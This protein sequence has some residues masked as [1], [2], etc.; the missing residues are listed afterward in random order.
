[1]TTRRMI[2]M[3]V[4]IL[5]V[6]GSAILAQQIKP[7]K[8]EQKIIL[9]SGNKD[10]TNTGFTVF[11]KDRVTVKASGKVYFSD[12]AMES[13]VGPEGWARDNYAA[14]FPED[15]NYCDDPLMSEN[16]A[17][18]IAD[19]NNERFLLGPETT[20]HGKDGLFYVGINDCSFAGSFFNSGQF[21]LVIKIERNVVPDKK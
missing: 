11:P 6:L 13:G 8:V 18:L 19:I 4:C 7:P 21:S 2:G 3:I 12:G 14:A 9:V 5:T 17:A 10:W 1:M 20:F 16:H 15:A